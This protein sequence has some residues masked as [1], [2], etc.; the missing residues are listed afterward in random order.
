[1]DDT[2]GKG[3]IVLSAAGHDRGKYFFVVETVGE[4]YLLLADGKFRTLEKPKKKKRKH[5][6]ICSASVSYTHLDVYKRQVFIWYPSMLNLKK[7]AS[8][9]ES[10]RLRVRFLPAR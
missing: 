8:R 7:P 6:R 9:A 3:G 2:V 10:L 4:D 5:C 1:M